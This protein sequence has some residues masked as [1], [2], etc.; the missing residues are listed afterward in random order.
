[1]D[2]CLHRGEGI[3]GRTLE[4]GN[5]AWYGKSTL[6]TPLPRARMA[7][8]CGLLSV[9]TVTVKTTEETIAI[10]E[11]FA[12]GERPP[13]QQLLDVLVAV[14]R[15]IGSVFEREKAMQQLK[16]FADRD[17]LTDLVVIRVARDRIERALL[18]A[19]RKNTICAVL[20]I[21]LDKFK[22]VNDLYGHAVGDKLLRHIAQ[23]FST[24]VRDVDTV[25]RMGG[26]EFIIVLSDLIDVAGVEKVAQNLL[27]SVAQ[28]ISIDDHNITISAS[29]G[30]ALCRSADK[31]VDGMIKQADQAMYL[32][33]QNGGN[34]YLV[35]TG[36][37]TE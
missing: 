27:D 18:W 13:D 24:S 36:N 33:K 26:D 6:N 20:F 14:G 19:K 12:A 16:Y 29:I 15:E 1:M 10:L 2:T 28:S 4:S 23:L 11:F 30:I 7:D 5:P 21:D 34:Q 25:A 8:K 22:P 32:A 17:S 37:Q 35:D 3:P 9:V 31:S